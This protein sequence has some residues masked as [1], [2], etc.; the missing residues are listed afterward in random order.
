MVDQRPDL[1]VHFI[2]W[3]EDRHF[4]FIAMEYIRHGDLSHYIKTPGARPN[5]REITR[6]LL[7]GLVILHERKICHRDL[8]PQV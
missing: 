4:T 5:A 2:G 1:F 3:Y 6:Q 8:K 7:E